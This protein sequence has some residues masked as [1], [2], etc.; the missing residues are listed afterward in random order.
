MDARP[1]RP[2]WMQRETE[3]I[4]RY[5]VETSNDCTHGTQYLTTLPTG[6]IVC[7]RCTI[8]AIAAKIT[9]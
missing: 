9:R 6:E 7:K 4:L 2:Q 3:R 8:A 5:T 1:N